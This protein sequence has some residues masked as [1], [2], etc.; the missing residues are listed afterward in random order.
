MSRLDELKKQYPELNISFFDIMVKMD[1]TKSHKYV[2]LMCKIF[3]KRFDMKSNCHKDDLLTFTFDIQSRLIDKGIS[4][5]N[6]TD[7]QMMFIST[8]LTDYYNNDTTHTLVNF[9]DY[10]DRGLIE[11]NDVSEYKNIDDLRAAITLASMKEFTKDLETQI[12][13]EYEDE[14]WLAVRPLTFSASAKYGASTRWCTTYQKEKNYFERY[15]RRGI[16]VYFINKKTGYKFAGYKGLNEETE[17]SFWTAEDNRID[18]LEIEV[19]DYLFPVVRKIFKSEYTNKNLCSE[20]I[21]EQVHMECI[22][23]YDKMRIEPVAVSSE[24]DLPEAPVEPTAELPRNY[25]REINRLRELLNDVDMTEE[26]VSQAISEVP[27]MRA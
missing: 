18:Y 7:N 10:M 12:I 17:F 25:Q 3:G 19:D 24:Y 14:T 8:L 23:Y 9:M 11:K 4:T 6:L 20:E 15:W 13:R 22:A 16:L 27:S 26:D 2:A 21:Q 5:E 1:T